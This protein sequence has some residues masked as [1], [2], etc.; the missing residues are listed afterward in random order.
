MENVRTVLMNENAILVVMVEGIAPD[1]IPAVADQHFF[2][3]IARKALGDYAAGI[4]G[5]NY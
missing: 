5:P 1:V 4:S 2:V 3:V